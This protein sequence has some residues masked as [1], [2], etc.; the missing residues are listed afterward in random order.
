LIVGT[1]GIGLG[2]LQ[3]DFPLTSYAELVSD[4][5]R[6]SL[7]TRGESVGTTPACPLPGAVDF[8]YNSVTVGVLAVGIL[9]NELLAT[10]FALG[11]RLRCSCLHSSAGASSSGRPSI[12]RISEMLPESVQISFEPVDKNHGMSSSQKW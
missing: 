6:V 8:Q 3:S 4:D 5:W 9:H 12:Y 1:D 7:G 11:N 10:V 2:E